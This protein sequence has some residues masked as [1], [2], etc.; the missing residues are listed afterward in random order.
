MWKKNIYK[1]K[2]MTKLKGKTDKSTILA[3]Q[4]NTSMV[5]QP[6]IYNLN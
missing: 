1:E 6:K 2:K 5:F 3:G 4:K